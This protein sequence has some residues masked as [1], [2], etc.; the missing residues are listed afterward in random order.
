MTMDFRESYKAVP[1]IQVAVPNIATILDT[2]ATVLGVPHA[3]LDLASHW[4]QTH[5]D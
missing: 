2:M 1:L 5:C 4:T 3:A